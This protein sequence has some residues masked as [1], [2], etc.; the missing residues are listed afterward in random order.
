VHISCNPDDAAGTVRQV[1]RQSRMLDAS[2]TDVIF[3]P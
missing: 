2:V 3:V 1:R